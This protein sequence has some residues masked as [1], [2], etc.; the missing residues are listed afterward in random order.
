[1][2]KTLAYYSFFLLLIV[3]LVLP[4][5]GN[6]GLFS[7][8]SLSFLSAGGAFFFYVLSRPTL[9]P[10]QAHAFLFLF[11]SLF[12]L[13]LWYLAGMGQDPLIP[14]GQ[15]DQFKV[16]LTTLFV[17]LASW[18]Y[19]KDGLI[20]PAQIFRCAI[21]AQA[22][23]CAL[24]VG[25]MT[26]HVL[27]I[28]N[29]W[30]L[31]EKTGLRFMSMNIVGDLGRIQTSVDIVT[32]FLLYF[33]L[34]SDTLGLKLGKKFRIFFVLISF[35]S[36]LLS[37]SRYL[38]AIYAIA[39]LLHGLT[40]AWNK[41][42]KYWALCL[43]ALT[44]G[45]IAA[46]PEKV[47]KAVEMRLF[48]SNN[49]YSDL[50]RRQQ[51][52]ALMEQCDRHPLFGAGLGGYTKACIRDKDI[53]HNYEVQW[54]AFLMQFGLLGIFLIL[55][56]LAY[57]GARFLL[58]PITSEKFGYLSLYTLWLLSGFTNPF[59]ISLTSG[60]IYTFFLIVPCQSALHSNHVID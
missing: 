42:A 17:P 57:I 37:F 50:D 23:Y 31:M 46:G 30:P 52:D 22:S 11:F 4:S 41:Q 15:F 51:V 36:T 45:V 27:K 20:A 10:S 59:L 26:L 58:P 19:I 40:L 8:K 34:Q 29:L 44:A 53:P 16:F 1:M 49:Y 43:L 35:A 18:Y 39:I 6:H 7:P 32:P 47:A 12:F 2:F 28:I 5:D 25:L 48:S 14:S 24:K 54:V 33:V 13:G 3:G 55:I 21:Y 60:I 56:P 38:I 9:R